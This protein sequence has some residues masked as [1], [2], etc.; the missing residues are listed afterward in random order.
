MIPGPCLWGAISWRADLFPVKVI[1]SCK[2]P[3]PW[4]EQG[5]RNGL[6]MRVRFDPGG[7]AAV[8]QLS[9]RAS[10]GP[11]RCLTYMWSKNNAQEDPWPSYYSRHL[12]REDAA[13][14]TYVTLGQKGAAK[15]LSRPQTRCLWDRFLTG[16]KCE[17]PELFNC[18]WSFNSFSVQYFVLPYNT[19][20]VRPCGHL[21]RNGDGPFVSV[22][23]TR[24]C[25][26]KARAIAVV[27][28]LS[29]Y[30]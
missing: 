23:N 15:W 12:A 10:H 28:Y 16:G 21:I 20:Y 9:H 11:Y 13:V 2:V 18:N 6:L 4:Q 5:L 1:I 27:Q 26:R 3:N 19:S 14:L 17:S 22:Q 25:E 8:R 7:S 30:S 29:S 24:C